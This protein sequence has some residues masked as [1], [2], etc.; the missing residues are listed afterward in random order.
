MVNMQRCPPGAPK[1][2]YACTLKDENRNQKHEQVCASPLTPLTSNT[3]V[4]APNLTTEDFR[5]G[6]ASKILLFDE[7]CVSSQGGKTVRKHL[8]A[9]RDLTY[10]YMCLR[11]PELPLGQRTDAPR[12]HMS[13]IFRCPSRHSFLSDQKG[14]P[15][16]FKKE[17]DV[18]LFVPSSQTSNSAQPLVCWKGLL[19]G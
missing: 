3:K 18:S 12:K 19:W 6:A 1:Y 9:L 10:R 5:T 2:T 17:M 7:F 11:Y 4:T 14:I 16:L 13:S 15:Y 8:L